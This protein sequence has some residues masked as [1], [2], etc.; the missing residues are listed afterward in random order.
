MRFWRSRSEPGWTGLRGR[1][2][3]REGRWPERRSQSGFQWFFPLWVR[4][5][6]CLLFGVALVG[7]SLHSAAQN[8]PGE[9]F[10]TNYSRFPV[11]AEWR[12]KEE[13]K[14]KNVSR[15]FWLSDDELMFTFTSDP[16]PSRVTD[17]LVG[18]WQL[19]SNM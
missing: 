16:L 10:V 2:S 13:L 9:T 17:Y 12:F 6:F 3:V 14:T 15:F 19:S 18:T 7:Y 1:V 11:I 8:I 5:V 4:G